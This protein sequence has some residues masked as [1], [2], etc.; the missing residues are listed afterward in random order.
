MGAGLVF[1]DLPET[2]FPFTVE[3]FVIRTDEMV[4]RIVVNGPG[5]VVVPP[6]API[7]GPIRIR[8]TYADGEI[9]ED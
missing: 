7:Y 9:A 8:I 3:F 6:L 5:A 2:S 1:R 4:H